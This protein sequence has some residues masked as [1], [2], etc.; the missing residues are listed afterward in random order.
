VRLPKAPRD[1]PRRTTIVATLGPATDTPDRIAE[2]IH[3]GADVFRL[4]FAHGTVEEHARRVA[5]VRA[6]ERSAGHPVAILQDLAGPKIR[7]GEIRGGAVEL[8]EGRPFALFTNRAAGGRVGSASGVG[9]TYRGLARDVR[10]G[11]RIFVDDGS[12]ELAVEGVRG[13]TVHTVVVRGGRLRPHKGINVPGVTL[14]TPTITPKDVRDLRA[15]VRM[16]VDYIALS[17]VR[18]PEDIDRARDLLRRLRV[19]LPIVAKLEKAEA[20]DALDAIIAV[21]DGVMVARGDL[22]VEISPEWV[23]IVQKK[24]IERANE[25]GIPVITATQMLESMTTNPRPT[26]AETSD[27]ANAI[28]DGTDAVMLSAETAVGRYPI[29]AVR[30]MHRIACAVESSAPSVFASRAPG[31]HGTARAVA[32]A[33]AT[34]AREIEA[35]AIAVITTTG[36]TAELLSKERPAT[37]LIAFAETEATARRLALWWGIT[38]YTTLF[39]EDTDAMIVHLES[40]LIR[41]VRAAAGDTIVLVGSAPVVARGRTNFLKVHR[42]RGANIA[43]RFRPTAAR[44]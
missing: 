19:A 41:R 7:T 20:L 31:R 9:T 15:G 16:G 2:L 1:W 23:P 34:V 22:G 42:V 24:V 13:G 10:R 17:F 32:H 25:A 44:R 27:V 4:N 26:R 43:A 40:E 11:N 5:A 12:I 36:R 28:L 29:E 39:M 8:R 21:S 33:A 38:C 6:A 35:R 30:T 3:A 18:R 14:R 37:P